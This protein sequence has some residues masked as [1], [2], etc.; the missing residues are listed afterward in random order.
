MF[1]NPITPT[2]I[3]S[4][5]NEEA[6]GF[7]NIHKEIN[8]DIY[9]FFK[10]LKNVYPMTGLVDL[11]RME[12]NNIMSMFLNKQ[13]YN[14]EWFNHVFKKFQEQDEQLLNDIMED[15]ASQSSSNDFALDWMH[16]FKLI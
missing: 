15:L 6:I 13:T 9:E 4:M 12:L 16:S 14:N 8:E 7:D 3:S 1:A 10:Y 5:S 11:F 2:L